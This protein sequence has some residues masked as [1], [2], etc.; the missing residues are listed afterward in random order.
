MNGVV[1]SFFMGHSIGQAGQIGALEADL[2][3]AE[4]KLRDAQ[5]N[6]QAS[7]DALTALCVL[8]IDALREANPDHP[9]TIQKNRQEKVNKVYYELL[10]N[11]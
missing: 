7:Y 4:R 1:G 11:S 2:E 5:K 3:I 9:L 10:G 8:L 6:A